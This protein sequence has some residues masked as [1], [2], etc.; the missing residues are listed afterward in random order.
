MQ[1][2]A[3]PRRPRRAPAGEERRLDAERSRRRL[4]A[5]ALE[6]F[7]AKGY[8][9]ARVADIAARAGVNKQLISYYFGGKAGL[10]EELQRTWLEREETVAPPELPLADLVPRYLQAVLADPR[11]TRLTLWRALSQEEADQPPEQQ[12]EDL[13]GMRRRQRDGELA[14]ELDP[15][16]ILLMLMALVSAPVAMPGE[17]SRILG[18]DPGSPE[19]EAHYAEQLR[20]VVRRL[21]EG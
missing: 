10:Y 1:N 13:T 4:L 6:E 17:V 5:A 9:G 7:A 3:E 18:L 8:A 11:H 21:A 19:F 14:A 15:G 16:A 2:P 20:R 12:A